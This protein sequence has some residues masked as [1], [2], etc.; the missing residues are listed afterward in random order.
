MPAERWVLKHGSKVIANL[1]ISMSEFDTYHDHLIVFEAIKASD[2]SRL[3]TRQP[4]KPLLPN[5][6]CK[7]DCLKNIDAF[8]AKFGSMVLFGPQIKSVSKYH[9]C[10]EH[11]LYTALT[12]QVPVLSRH[13]SDFEVQYNPL[14]IKP[15]VLQ[16]RI[17]TWMVPGISNRLPVTVVRCP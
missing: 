15:L 1:Q 3:V 13:I 7:F 12:S 11:A 2:T 9:K 16:A 5:V 17:A 14:A 4:C 6:L 8:I 10:F